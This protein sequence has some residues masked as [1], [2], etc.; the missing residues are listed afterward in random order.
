MPKETVDVLMGGYL[1]KDAAR[2]GLRG[3]PEVRRPA[4]RGGRRQQG[5]GRHD[6]RSSSTTTSSRR[7]RRPSAGP[8][9][10]SA[11]SRHRVLV[12]TAVG[13]GHRRGRR[14]DR[15]QE[16]GDQARG[17]GGADHPHR[18]CRAHRHLRPQ[19]RRA[20]RGGG[21]PGHQEGH[22]RGDR[23]PRQGGQGRA[24]GRRGE[25]GGFGGLT[26]PDRTRARRLAIS[27]EG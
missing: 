3:R 11:S 20:R 9:S 23:Q 21:H 5:P 8:A 14:Q 15:P 10:S 27:R 16:G 18:W 4:A 12:A 19:A 22:R 26:G 25:D 24:C 2:R 6:G 1:S 13:R 7:A 17:A